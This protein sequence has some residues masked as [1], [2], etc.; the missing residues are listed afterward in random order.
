[1]KKIRRI[2]ALSILFSFC[3]LGVSND[4]AAKAVPS[5]WAATEVSEAIGLGFIPE[6]LQSDYQTPITRLEFAKVALAFC[7]MQYRIPQNTLY[8][9]Y[10][11]V[12]SLRGNLQMFTDCDDG[13]A[14]IAYSIGIV[15]GKGNG[16]FDPD[17]PITRQE[18]A[19]MLIRAYK[20]YAG[21]IDNEFKQPAYK[22][23]SKIADWAVDGV[24][25]MSEWGVMNGVGNDSFAPDKNYTREQCYITFLRLY[26]NATVSRMHKN[27]QPLFT[28]EEYVDIALHKDE[29]LSYVLTERIDTADFIVLGAF[30]G[31]L[32]HGNFYST[33][34]VIY[35]DAEGGRDGSLR[36]NDCYLD[37]FEMDENG[38]TLYCTVT[39]LE[40]VKEISI[41]LNT[42]EYTVLTPDD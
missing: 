2:L 28:P 22:D 24:S 31:G 29:A 13:D 6:H 4:A 9:D 30:M 20:V 7:A 25:L 11:R 17:A 35:K 36:W 27:V 26:K 14:E 42:C 32:P 21:D 5:D 8:E 23:M 3:V 34:I 40:I 38:Y 19:T 39:Y 16:I 18:A 33:V 10:G 37:N 1:M 12:H 41:D 15:E